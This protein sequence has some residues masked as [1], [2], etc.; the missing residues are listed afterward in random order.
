MKR[1]PEQMVDAYIDLCVDNGFD[2]NT[3]PNGDWGDCGDSD[4]FANP[5]DIVD[6]PIVLIE[7]SQYGQVWIT[8]HSTLEAACKANTDQEYAQDWTFP[9]IVDIAHDR[10]YEVEYRQMAVPIRTEAHT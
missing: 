2:G 4:H 10:H 5:V 6:E 9:T 8:L 1:T 7:H 3:G